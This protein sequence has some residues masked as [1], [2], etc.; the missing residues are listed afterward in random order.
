MLSLTAPFKFVPLTYPDPPVERPPVPAPF[1]ADPYPQY[2]EID[3]T[4]KDI[5]DGIPRNAH[6]CAAAKAIARRFDGADV[7]VGATGFSVNGQRYQDMTGVELAAFISRFDAGNPTRPTTLHC[8]RMA[9][10][11]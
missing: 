1:R 8:R 4:L 6:H 11:W 9:P 2:V 10:G 7:T 5:F 3:I